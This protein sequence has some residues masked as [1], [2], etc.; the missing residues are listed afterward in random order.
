MPIHRIRLKAPWL[1]AA[2][3]QGLPLEL[4]S[5]PQSSKL[6]LAELLA[7]LFQARQ[8]P[9]A[10]QA[11]RRF[12]RPTGLTPSSRV[13]VCVTSRHPPDRVLFGPIA[14]GEPASNHLQSLPPSRSSAHSLEFALPPDLQLRSEIRLEWE[15]LSL[16]PSPDSLLVELLI[17]EP[18]HS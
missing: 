15:Q 18:E 12:H 7:R 8:G 11:T 14:P 13:S 5:D 1:V 6:D 4:P 2:H 9:I 17:R 3:A 10:V 16:E